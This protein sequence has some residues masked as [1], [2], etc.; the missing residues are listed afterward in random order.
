MMTRRWCDLDGLATERVW[1]I[2]RVATGEGHAITE[3]ADVIDDE[4]LNHAAPR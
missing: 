2:N 4:T 3:M 1:H